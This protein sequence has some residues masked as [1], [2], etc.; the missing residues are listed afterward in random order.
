MGGF[1]SSLAIVGLAVWSYRSGGIV[2]ILL[3]RGVSAG[4][5]VT[6]IQ[7]YFDRS[8]LSLRLC[9]WGL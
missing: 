4:E 6:R 2:S 5:R 7:E 8:A 1:D 3:A 9:I